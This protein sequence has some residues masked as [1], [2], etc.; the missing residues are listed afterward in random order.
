M[1]C[2]AADLFVCLFVF[3]YSFFGRVVR[4]SIF[5]ATETVAEICEALTVS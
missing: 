5:V 1:L 4:G 2:G 3:I